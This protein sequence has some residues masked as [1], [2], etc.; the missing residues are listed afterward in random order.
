MKTKL[1]SKRALLALCV[2][3][4]L[5]AVSCDKN[6]DD[7]D[8]NTQT[9]NVSG[10]GSGSQVVPSVTTTATSTLTGTYNSNTNNLQ[11]TIS[12]TG[13]AATANT[14]RFYGPASAGTNATGN[15]QYDAAITA[16]GL[17]GSASGNI[18]LTAAQETDLLAGNWYYLIGNTTYLAGEVR[19]QITATVQ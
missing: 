7:M 6:D 2:G 17:N 19:G 13:L 9:Y 16:P 5:F 10:S 3:V 1:F 14:V 8:N 18:T 11:Y 4:S 15:A 12:W